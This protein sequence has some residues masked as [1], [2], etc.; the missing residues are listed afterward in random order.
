MQFIVAHL[1]GALDVCRTIDVLVICNLYSRSH[2]VLV[3]KLHLELMIESVSRKIC[4]VHQCA[5][6]GEKVST[7]LARDTSSRLF[8]SMS[9]EDGDCRCSR[10]TVQVTHS[11]TVSVTCAVVY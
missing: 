1:F 6:E 10:R 11:L 7:N 9:L 3:V 8:E 2:V 5:G 4:F